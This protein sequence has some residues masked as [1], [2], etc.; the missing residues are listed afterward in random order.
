[1]T[2]CALNYHL[3]TPENEGQF[4]FR[5]VWLPPLLEN[6]SVHSIPV[7]RKV[8]NLKVIQLGTVLDDCIW[9]GGVDLSEALVHCW[10]EQRLVRQS[11]EAPV[12]GTCLK[13]SMPSPA[14][15]AKPADGPAGGSGNS[16][17]LS[18][19]WPC[20]IAF[21]DCAPNLGEPSD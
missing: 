5:G 7:P 1:M 14:A 21:R 11:W 20:L 16:T 2:S 10:P 9:R 4:Y 18:L 8:D 13:T 6:S 3:G 19:S 17:F 12:P 15:D